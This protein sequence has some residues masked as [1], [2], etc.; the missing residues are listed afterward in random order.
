MF[1]RTVFVLAVAGVLIAGVAALTSRAAA[2]TSPYTWFAPLVDIER[3]IA[4]R[5]VKDPDL[6]QMQTDAIDGMIDALN[7]PYT[8]YIP[9]AGISDFDKQVRGRYVG[10]GASVVMKD[11]E[12][13]IVSPLDDSPAL[14]AG[15]HAGDTVILVD[16]KPTAGLSLTDTVGLLTGEPGS[17][18]V[19]TVRRDGKTLDIP[20]VRRQIVTRTVS[21][22]KRIGEQWDY[23]IDPAHKIG[24]VRLSQFNANSPKELKAALDTMIDQGAQ[25]VVLDLRFN[26]GGLVVAAT[27]IAD[28]FLDHGLIVKTKGRA[29]PEQSIYATKEGTEPILP[30]AVLINRQSASSSEIL[31]GALRDNDRA[32]IVGTR[33]FGKGVM[34][35]VIAL[36]S[37]AGQLKI[38]EQYYYGP[39]GKMIH[40]TDD[41]TDWGV[42]PDDGFFVTMSDQQYRDMLSA[43]RD[44]D[45]IRPDPT[46]GLTPGETTEWILTELKD[47]Q[48]AAAV[49]GMVGELTTGTWTPADDAS[50]NTTLDLVELERMKKARQAIQRDL[51]RVQRRIAALSS[52]APEDQ[53]P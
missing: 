29:H 38:T 32:V 52:V 20:V 14:H 22:W 16:K 24:Y 11:G 44:N 9:N 43:Q 39:S 15:I 6:E 23:M 28:L 4:D 12:V 36:P 7:D 40:R 19:V 27:Q 26:P 25:G 1:R 50:D 8:V 30:L 48:L 45:I 37:G 13:T 17:T 49:D 41:S 46:A 47:K 10:I 2:P 34:Q 33:S 3:I 5:Y 35:S 51:D 31:S 42:D 18:V 53:L 21:G